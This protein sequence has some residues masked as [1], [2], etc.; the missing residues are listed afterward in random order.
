MDDC[1]I[2]WLCG[3]FTMCRQTNQ[4]PASEH[5]ATSP[6]NSFITRAKLD[7]H[8]MRFAARDCIDRQ[9]VR[10]SY[11]RM[12]FSLTPCLVSLIEHGK[13]DVLIFCIG[14][15]LIGRFLPHC[16]EK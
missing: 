10:Y 6:P 7:Q 3:C 14:I 13:L 5:Q 15:T 16:S 12:S 9:I 8:E 11:L 2:N 1:G 4:T